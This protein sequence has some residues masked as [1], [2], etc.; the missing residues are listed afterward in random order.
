[1]ILLVGAS[2]SGK[3]E[4]GKQLEKKYNFTKVVTYTT[5]QKRVN[6]IDDVDYHFISK[7]LFL[8]FKESNF[9]FE[10]VYYNENFYGTALKDFLINSYLIVDSKG[11]KEYKNSNLFTVSFFLYTNEEIRKERMLNRGDNI[12]DV[13]RRLETDSQHFDYKKIEGIDYLID[14]SD[15]SILEITDKIYHIYENATKK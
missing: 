5:R 14:V 10:T 9:F 13:L 15:N 3:T 2:A 8:K 11:L 6:E 12:N 1:M 7:D 4:I